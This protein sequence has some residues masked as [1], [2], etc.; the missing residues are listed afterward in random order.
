MDPALKPMHISGKVYYGKAQL[1]ERGL[2]TERLLV[3]S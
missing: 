3:N 1:I 2:V